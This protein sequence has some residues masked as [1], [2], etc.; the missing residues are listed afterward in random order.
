MTITLPKP[1]QAENYPEEKPR[2]SWKTMGLSPLTETPQSL[3][4]YEL[5]EKIGEG[6]LGPVYRGFD[7]NLRT[8]VAIRILCD[9]IKWSPTIEEIFAQEAKAIADM[10]HP[11]IATVLEI[12][13]EGP[14]HYIVMESLGNGTLEGLL[15]QDPTPSIEAKLSIMIHVS[16]GLSYA[17]K[18]GILHRDLVP[19][20]IHLAPDGSAKVRDFSFAHILKKYLPH[21]VVRWGAPIYLCPEQIQQKECD[22]RSDIFSAGTIF[23]QLITRVHPFHDQ[24]SNKALDN[25]LSDTPIP[26]FDKFPDAP[27]GIWTILRNCLAKDPAERYGS[28]AEFSEA[29]REL[30]VSLAED[31]QIILSELYASLS[32]LKKA[33]AQPGAAASTIALL[34]DIQSLLRGE[35]EADYECLDRLMTDLTEEYPAIQAAASAP[36]ELDSLCP[37]IPSA[38]TEDAAESPGFHAPLSAPEPLVDDE[39]QPDFPAPSQKSAEEPSLPAAESEDHGAFTEAEVGE[40]PES[41]AGAHTSEGDSENPQVTAGNL[42]PPGAA[43]GGLNEAQYV[44]LP[45]SASRYLKLRRRSYRTAVVLLSLLVIA[46]AGYILLGSDAASA[47]RKAWNIVLPPSGNSS[48]LTVPKFQSNASTY[49][50]TGARTEGTVKPASAAEN[51]GRFSVAHDHGVFGGACRGILSFDSKEVAFVPVSGSHGFRIPFALL[52]LKVDGNSLVLYYIAYNT[53][54]Q[55]FVAPDSQTAAR[56]QEKWN[57]LKAALH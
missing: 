8:P 53:H 31:K 18:H 1:S 26:T 9:G 42:Q 39:E 14:I 41:T 51:V 15:A 36:V 5:V 33:A 47:F 10:R 29:C 54:F 49:T 38:G 7:Q 17:H 50:P 12:G 56:F 23:Y 44:P 34:N 25:I 32:P 37:Q 30:L 35:K 45:P 46:I 43:P 57:E 4:N 40:S 27:P 2:R 21:P 28:A 52:R 22:N 19:G 16:E 55:T 6:Y 24:D 3:G 11:N 48:R 20:K 13:R